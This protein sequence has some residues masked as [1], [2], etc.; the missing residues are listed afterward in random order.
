MD[1][2]KDIDK[3]QRKVLLAYHQDGIL[4]LV[5]GTVVLGFGLNMLTDN[6]A[7]LMIGWLA[8]I[9]YI[10][11]K[12][13]ITIPRFG[14]VRFESEKASFKKG[15]VSVGVGVLLVLFILTLNIFVSRR[16][17]SP[18]IQAWLQRYHMVPL[19]AMIFGL[20]A[21]VAAT[22]LQLKRFYLYALLTAS[23]PALGAWLNVETYLPIV[24]T[25]LIL[26]TFGTVLLINFLKKYPLTNKESE[27][28]SG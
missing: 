21:L 14:Y 22:F 9:L 24:T 4:D 3:L 19:S 2:N 25:G 10:L 27:D 12:Q 11:I 5:A 16:P 26:M 23:L 13:R 6:I 18:D 15:V 1:K 7:F 20:P 28:V 17:T 8:M